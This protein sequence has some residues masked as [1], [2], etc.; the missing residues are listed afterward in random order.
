M[1]YYEEMTCRL[2]SKFLECRSNQ[3]FS[4]ARGGVKLSEKQP[5]FYHDHA[6][7]VLSIIMIMAWVSES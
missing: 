7:V 2:E 1:N 3:Y 6:I 4:A 5:K